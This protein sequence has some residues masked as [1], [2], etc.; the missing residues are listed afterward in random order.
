MDA[1]VTLAS[2]AT[3][4]VRG[5]LSSTF[6]SANI[7]AYKVDTQNPNFLVEDTDDLQ[8]VKHNDI[9]TIETESYM[10]IG[11]PQKDGTGLAKLMIAPA[12]KLDNSGEVFTQ[13]S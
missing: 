7:G 1:V 13:I 11:A 4:N 8:N 6:K 9:L 10:I 2:G 3:L 12:D 5:I